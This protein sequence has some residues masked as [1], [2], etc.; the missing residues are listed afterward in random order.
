MYCSA[1]VGIALHFC[2]AFLVLFTGT[3]YIFFIVYF[4]YFI[5]SLLYILF[6]VYLDFAFVLLFPIP[7]EVYLCGLW[8][9]SALHCMFVLHFIYF[10]Y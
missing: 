2:F 5:F 9:D 10:I 8:L 6:V 3:L 4:L 1:F 7:S